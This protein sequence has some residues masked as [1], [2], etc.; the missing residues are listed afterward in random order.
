MGGP[1]ADL[2]A[3]IA[4]ARE[5][6][7][8]W[9]LAHALGGAGSLSFHEGEGDRAQALLRESVAVCEALGDS[10]I[11]NTSRFWLGRS[12]LASGDRA[13]G[14]ATLEAVAA[15]ARAVGDTFSLPMALTHLGVDHA[16]HGEEALGLACLD[17][18]AAIARPVGLPRASQLANALWAKAIVLLAK[19]DPAAAAVLDEFMVLI[20]RG[21]GAGMKAFA[22]AAVAMAAV[23]NGDTETADVRLE[24]ARTA[25]SAHVP[26]SERAFVEMVA[27]AA[28]RARGDFHAAAVYATEALASDPLC[29]DAPEAYWTIEI[30]ETLAG[31][32]LA[33]GAARDAVRLR[34]AADTERHRIR[35]PRPGSYAQDLERDLAIARQ[36][37]G[38]PDTDAAWAEGSALPIEEAVAFALGR[39]L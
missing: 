1:R 13:A 7:D 23:L 38:D 4:L 24:Q 18:A 14:M 31:A 12:L 33:A 16:F 17:E 25:L 20:D 32:L 29:A 28:A 27:A 9:C 34:A 19:Q 2:E 22:C 5:I 21:S 6:G 37:L 8:S 26:R 10:Y 11:I 36:Q 39:T 30:L 3:S 35:R 15:H